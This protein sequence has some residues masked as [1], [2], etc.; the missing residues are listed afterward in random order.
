[1]KKNNSRQN[2]PKLDK[3]EPLEIKEVK[4]K[5]EE[6]KF[7]IIDLDS[8]DDDKPIV[9][10]PKLNKSKEKKASIQK[11][12][13]FDL[14]SIPNTNK[15]EGKTIVITGVLDNYARDDMISLITKMKG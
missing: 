4:P 2:T 5:K 9:K 8:S 6:E 3:K 11:E 13:T 10:K 1:M 12:S 14:S 7:K 15:I